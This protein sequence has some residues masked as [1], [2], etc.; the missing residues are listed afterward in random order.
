M[1]SIHGLVFNRKKDNRITNYDLCAV[2]RFWNFL[3]NTVPVVT[4]EMLETR[5]S[6]SLQDTIEFA[7]KR[8]N[9]FVK[10]GCIGKSCLDVLQALSPRC[11]SSII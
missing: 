5:A 2:M 10:A 7:D 11:A 4:K 1:W 9:K 6:A 3:S 8:L